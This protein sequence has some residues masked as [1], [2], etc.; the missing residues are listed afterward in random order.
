MNVLFPPK[1]VPGDVIGVTAPSSGVPEHLHPRLELAIANLKKKGFQVREGSCLRSQHKNKSSSKL[2]RAEELMSFLNDP[3]IKAVMPPWGG[4]LAMELLELIDFKLLARSK[5]KWF[6][7][8][9]DLSTIHFPLT[10]ISGWATLHGPNLMDLGAQELDDTTQSV[11][12]ILESNRGTIIKQRSSTA[13]Q[14]EE[15][16]WGTESDQ[17][18]NLTQKTHWKRLDGVTSSITF[19]GKL[20]GGCLEIISRL[21]GTPFGN[22][23]FFKTS[24]SDQGIILYFENV[25]MAPC[26]LTRALLSLRL[27]GW[28]DN[29]N[30]VLIGRSAAPDIT[31]STKHNYLDAL[32]A[33]FEDLP[34]PVLYD[35][36]IGH[37]PPQ[38]SLVNGADATILFAEN[39]SLLTQQL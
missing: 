38:I 2:S 1:L 31:D 39:G 14:V 17:G 26:E 5:P 10:T 21:A 15:N 19:S 27:Q 6:V 36:D 30:G 12:E 20:I 18:F 4:D 3:E 34:V 13:F 25:E 29:L 33:A 28:F 23:P 37:V 16:Q 24:N 32:K 9:S 22:L 35:V 11:W 8:F 7:G